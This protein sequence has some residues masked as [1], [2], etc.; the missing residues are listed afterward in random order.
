MSTL[1]GNGTAA[2][3]DGTGTSA[4]F[5]APLGIAVGPNGLFVADQN[6][7]KLRS[8]SFTGT[9]ATIAGSGTS[10]SAD[11]IGNVATF[12]APRG[13]AYANGNLYVAEAGSNHIRQVSPISGASVSTS[14]AGAPRPWRAREPR[15]PRMARGISRSLTPLSARERF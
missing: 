7:N 13:V 15:V 11:G 1:A 2:E 10:G 4:S 3:T 12:N 6:G 14:Q 9:V 5:N 8:V